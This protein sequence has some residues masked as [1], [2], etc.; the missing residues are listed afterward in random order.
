[1][2]MSALFALVTAEGYEGILFVLTLIA[3]SGQRKP[4]NPTAIT[5]RLIDSV[6][7]RERKAERPQ[8]QQGEREVKR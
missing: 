8:D 6:G 7:D 1:M 2:S 3:G 4:R 5:T